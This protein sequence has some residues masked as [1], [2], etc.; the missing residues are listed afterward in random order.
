MQPA[1]SLLQLSHVGRRRPG[2]SGWL[3]RDVSLDLRGGDRLALVGPTGAGKTLLLRSS[4]WLDPLDEGELLWRGK[5]LVADD[6]PS[7]RSRAIYLHQ[8]P[9]LLP[10]TVAANLRVSFSLSANRRRAYDPEAAVA[11]LRQVGRDESFVARSVQD[12]SGGES[13]IVAVVRALSLQ[14]DVLLLDE[15]TASLDAATAGAIEGLISRWFD[16]QRSERAW[17]W[18][19]HDLDQAR[20]MSNRLLRISAGEI[21]REPR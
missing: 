16:E 2:G 6:I 18:V 3:F 9:A 4:A 15:P 13:Q 20:R 11:L 7:F 12:L 17:I 14:P 19:T 1:S 10:G 5:P 8:R 21:E